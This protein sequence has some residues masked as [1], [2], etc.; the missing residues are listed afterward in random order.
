MHWQIFHLVFVTFRGMPFL[1]N[2]SL[3]FSFQL[4]IREAEF[5]GQ[6]ATV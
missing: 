5:E 4:N 2:S 3:G 6:T 1:Y